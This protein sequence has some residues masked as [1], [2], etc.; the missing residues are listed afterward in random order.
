MYSKKRVRLVLVLLLLLLLV[1]LVSVALISVVLVVVVLVV[2]PS[3]TYTSL[4]SPIASYGD[5]GTLVVAVVF[6]FNEM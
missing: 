6:D 1:A 5:A 2:S 3:G 4:E